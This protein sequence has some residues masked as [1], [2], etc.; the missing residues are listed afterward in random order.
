MKIF[1][2]AQMREWDAFTLKEEP[3]TSLAL[4]ERAATACVHWIQERDYGNATFHVFCGK[5]N[6][7]GDGLAI[8]RLLLEKGKMVHVYILETGQKGTPDFQ[9]NLHRLHALT[10]EI[11]FIQSEQFFPQ[12]RKDAVVVDALLGTGLQRPLEG[13][14]ALLAQHINQAGATVI[15]IDIPSGMY[16][17]Q[18][19]RLL[20]KIHATHTLTFQAWKLCFLMEENQE[21]FGEVHL[22]PIGLHRGYEPVTPVTARMIDEA[23]IRSLK[24]RRSPFAHKGHFGHALLVGGS[25]GKIGA[26]VLSSR[27]CLKSG[28]GLVT[29]AI[30][31]CGYTVLQTAVPE[32]MV[33]SDTSTTHISQV[34]R[35]LWRFQAVGIGPGMGLHEETGKALL[36]LLKEL[37]IPVVLDADALNL[38]SMV[39]N[40]RDFLPPESILT[41]HPKE[42]ERLFGAVTDNFD[43]LERARSKASEW[44]CYILLKTHHTLIACPDGQLWFNNTGNSGMAKAGSGDVLTGLL[45]GLLAQGYTP[46]HA[47]ILGVYLHGLAGD[48]AAEQ[49]GEEAMLASDTIQMLGSAFR[50]IR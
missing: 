37:H 14:A 19:C 36:Q 25:Y 9:A 4:M 34:P 21:A 27:A 1:S 11:H 15:A 13:T 50:K 44:N 41:P 5:G 10:F 6:N 7:G 42:F 33:Q 17:D 18:T 46:E 2:A 48:L 47:C 28:A 31:T 30:P 38:L 22:L 8:A 32:T 12:L 35:E 45:T 49:Q 3:I 29:A 26:M 40:A 20:P 16:A 39:Q 24:K 23:L 43:R